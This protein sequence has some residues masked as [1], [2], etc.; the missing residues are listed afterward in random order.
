[1]SAND[2]YFVLQ[3]RNLR[4]ELVF[5]LN[6]Q[7]HFPIPWYLILEEGNA[8]KDNYYRENRQQCTDVPHLKKSYLRLPTLKYRLPFGFAS[9]GEEP[10][11]QKRIF[12][13]G[14]FTSCQEGL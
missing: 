5:L 6:E 3:L 2:R 8:S 13:F 11:L 9:P 7:F 1:L 4:P 12:I 14:N 10:H